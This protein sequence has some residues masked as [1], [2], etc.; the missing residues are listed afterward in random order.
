MV[1]KQRLNNIFLYA[2]INSNKMSF[3]SFVSPIVHHGEA[4][5]FYRRFRRESI[6]LAQIHDFSRE[7]IVSIKRK[8]PQN[9][10]QIIKKYSDLIEAAK[11]KKIVSQYIERFTEDIVDITLRFELRHNDYQSISPEIKKIYLAEL[12]LFVRVELEEFEKRTISI[13]EEEHLY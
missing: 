11:N 6:L 1:L 2:K 9:K 12:H 5:L 10:N 3:M 8:I 4:L 7:Q 13:P